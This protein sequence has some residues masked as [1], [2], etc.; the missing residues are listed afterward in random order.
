[1][2]ASVRIDPNRSGPSAYG[3]GASV[4]M[5]TVKLGPAYNKVVGYLLD[6]IELPDGR[7]ERLCELLVDVGT[8][9][10]LLQLGHTLGRDLEAIQEGGG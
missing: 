1:V 5:F 7:R 4:E 2:S 10:Q 6:V 8:R 3:R 9:S